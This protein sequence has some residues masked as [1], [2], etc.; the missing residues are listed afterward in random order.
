[1][2]AWQ[3]TFHL[4]PHERVRQMLAAAY[5]PGF[6]PDY[7]KWLAPDEVRDFEWWREHQPPADFR[8][9]LDALAP[10]CPAWATDVEWWGSED[11]DRFDVYCNDGRIADLVVRFDLRAPNEAFIVGVAEIAADL[12]ADFVGDHGLLY[13]GS[14]VGLAVGLRNSAALRFVEDPLAFLAR[15]RADRPAAG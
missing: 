11:G 2:A 7:I 15:V 1:M 5:H 13:E 10:R 14:S 8:G 6:E 4:V 9:A 12:A 3:A